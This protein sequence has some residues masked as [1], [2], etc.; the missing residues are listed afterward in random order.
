M[1]LIILQTDLKPNW[2]SKRKLPTARL[3]IAVYLRS[4]QLQQQGWALPVAVEGGRP[5]PLPAQAPAP[6]TV[7]RVLHLISSKP[8]TWTWTGTMKLSSS[9][10]E[11]VRIRDSI[12]RCR[13]TRFGSL[14]VHASKVIYL[15][16]YVLA[17]LEFD[18]LKKK[19]AQ[20]CE[21]V[22]R[23]FSVCD[24]STVG[25]MIAV[26]HMSARGASH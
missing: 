17:L 9:W 6:C 22:S 15:L 25:K 19:Y 10:Q 24:L 23:V 11:K 21:Q 12:D 14:K 7:A 3:A 20:E 26:Y 1:I 16:L 13:P 4:V 18:E 5:H 2:L 8:S